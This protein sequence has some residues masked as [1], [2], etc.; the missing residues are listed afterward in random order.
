MILIT[1]GAGYIGSHTCAV[2]AQANESFIILD[3]FSNTSHR[4]VSRLTS[5]LGEKP[6]C[7]EGD[8]RD[9]GLLDSLFKNHAIT[10]VIHF[11]G[12]KYVGE[13]I[14]KPL[15]YYDNNLPGLLSLLRAMEKAKVWNLVFSSSAGVYGS[16]KQNPVK[17]DFPMAPMSPYGHTKAMSEQI[18]IDLKHQNPLWHF[19]ALRYFNPIGAHESGKIGEE[20]LG[21][22][23]NLLPYVTKVAIK[24]LPHLNIF[25]GDYATPDGTP[26][27]DYLHVMDLA[28]GHVSAL[29]HIRE[30][31]SDMLTVNF[32][33]GHGMSVLEIV[34][35]FEKVIGVSIPYKIMPR[36]EGDSPECWA[37]TQKAAQLLNWKAKRG[38]DQMLADAWQWQCN[39]NQGA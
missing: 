37:D 26:V 17:E 2:L 10:D 35:S 15:M 25:G 38:L 33:A 31:G 34:A 19:A 30:H 23:N 21:I 32:G 11:A 9:T 8:V 1:G 13:S 3:N 5:L 22:P 28:E 4:A 12:S 18:L 6:L 24:E 39:M 27:R 29:R 16:P 7:I 20:A 14:A 36:R